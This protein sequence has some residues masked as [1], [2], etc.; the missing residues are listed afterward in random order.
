M[1]IAND[2][3][4]LFDILLS[5]LKSNGYTTEYTSSKEIPAADRIHADMAIV[6]QSNGADNTL[7]VGDITLDMDRI[8]AY[9]QSGNDIHLTPIEFG[10]LSYLMKNAHRAVPRTELIRAVWG[11][12]E[13]QHTRVAD[14]TAK[15]LR[16]KLSHSALVLETVW[17]YG[18]RV[19]GK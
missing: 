3:D 10:M 6:Y 15:R 17:N 14:D 7:A 5:A 4:K 16:R 12:T 19:R 13:T 2:D 9:D 8:R 18:F 11:Y 1:Y